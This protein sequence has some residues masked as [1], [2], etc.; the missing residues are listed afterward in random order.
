MKAPAPGNIP[1]AQPKCPGRGP[2]PGREVIFMGEKERT[3]RSALASWGRTARLCTIYVVS[4]G[5]IPT[6][7]TIIVL[8]LHGA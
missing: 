2:K 7:V 5:G 3:V 4:N 8:K 1:G 6:I